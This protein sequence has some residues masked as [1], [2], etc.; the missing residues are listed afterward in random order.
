MSHL[1]P[2]HSV[3]EKTACSC[4]THDLLALGEYLSGRLPS[5][6]L[7]QLQWEWPPVVVTARRSDHSI[8]VP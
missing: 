4:H 5:R 3:V 1:I 6:P 2:S 7:P 8:E